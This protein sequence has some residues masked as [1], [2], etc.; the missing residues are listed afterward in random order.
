MNLMLERLC[1]AGLQVD[2]RKCKFNVEET[3]FLSVI[4]SEQG[5]QMDPQKVKAILDWTTPTKLREIQE[6]IKFVNF[7]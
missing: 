7:Y 6:F 3:T 1:E 4:V 2:I 5:L